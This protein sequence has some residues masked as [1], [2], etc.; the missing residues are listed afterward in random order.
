MAFSLAA[1]AASFD[2]LPTWMFLNSA[3]LLSHAAM[4]N[5]DV[6]GNANHMLVKWLD[7]CRLNWWAVNQKA[8]RRY[9]TSQD[10]EKDST[11]LEGI[12]SRT[13]YMHS[14]S[15]NLVM[16]VG[17]AIL[18]LGIWQFC[19]IK[20]CV[21]SWTRHSSLRIFRGRHEPLATNFALRFFYELFLDMCIVIMLTLFFADFSTFG[22]ELQWVIA[23]VF[24]VGLILLLIGLTTF[25]CWNGPYHP[26]YFAPGSAIA[27]VFG[28]PLYNPDIRDYYE[29][30]RRSRAS[31]LGNWNDMKSLNFSPG[32]LSAGVAWSWLPGYNAKSPAAEAGDKDV[33]VEYVDGENPPP[34][35]RADP[36]DR[37]IV[38]P[39]A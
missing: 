3:S 31:R 17:I 6:P 27:S 14:F 30:Q 32:L 29:L 8:A 1:V 38:F 18:L 4:I 23:V 26:G 13:G 19:A 20:D 15:L 36:G 11:Y 34:T 5:V 33:E 25:F 2:L 22:T 7:L 39:V 12:L 35:E 21:G 24:G 37:D 9:G 10:K 16:L 28:T